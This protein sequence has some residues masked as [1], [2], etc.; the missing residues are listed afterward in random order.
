MKHHLTCTALGAM[1]IAVGSA[2]SIRSATFT[3]ASPDP[4]SKLVDPLVILQRPRRN[5]SGDI[6]QYTSYVAGARLIQLP[7]PAA[8]GPPAPAHASKGNS[9]RAIQAAVRSTSTNENPATQPFTW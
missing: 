6:F 7:P 3:G 4:G 9:A 1:W 8:G 5:D 2:C